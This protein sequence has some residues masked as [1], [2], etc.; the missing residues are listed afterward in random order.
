MNI[1]A[2]THET[3]NLLR[4]EKPSKGI[5][6]PRREVMSPFTKHMLVFGAKK[7]NGTAIEFLEHRAIQSTRPSR[8]GSPHSLTR[9]FSSKGG[10]A[11]AVRTNQWKRFLRRVQTRDC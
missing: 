11:V 4:T 3:T 1:G 7:R 5:R 6:R 10:I 2:K 8:Y 9:G